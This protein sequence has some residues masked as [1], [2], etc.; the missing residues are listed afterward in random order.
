MAVL[1]K[2]S[3]S[4]VPLVLAVALVAGGASGCGRGEDR[5]GIVT[6]DHDESSIGAEE[7]PLALGPS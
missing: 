7:R 2:A 3:R 5:P 1:L 4:L 6:S